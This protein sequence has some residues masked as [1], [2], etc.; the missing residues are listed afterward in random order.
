MTNNRW[1]WA[2]REGPFSPSPK[3][4]GSDGRRKDRDLRVAW[5][6]NWDMIHFSHR[7]GKAPKTHAGAGG[8]YQTRNIEI[9]VMRVFEKDCYFLLVLFSVLE[10]REDLTREDKRSV[11]SGER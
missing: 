6:P 9:R 3:D 7:K 4:H 11:L 1:R 5:E 8:D 10:G 2:T